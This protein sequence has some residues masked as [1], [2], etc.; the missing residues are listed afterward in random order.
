MTSAQIFELLRQF[1]FG[2]V[3]TLCFGMLFGIPR[4]CYLACATTGAVGWLAYEL[5]VML[6]VGA[7]TANLLAAIPLTLLARI[8]AVTLKAP[9]TVFLLSGIFPLVPGAGIYYTA[10]YF[11][12][13]DNV[14]MAASAADT[15][16][17]AA[18]LAI[19]ISLVLGLPFPKS[20]QYKQATQPSAEDKKQK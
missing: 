13:N 8:F 2:G 14:Q 10:Y 1:I 11:I 12:Q 16:K 18:A 9:V 19:S 15:V 3:G 17:I 7:V 6:G 20:K 4:K 5:A